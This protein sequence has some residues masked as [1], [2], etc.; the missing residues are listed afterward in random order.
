VDKALIKGDVN[1]LKYAKAATRCMAVC[2]A[3]AQ[4][5]AH[6][7]FTDDNS[8]LA[9]TGTGVAQDLQAPQQPL[10]TPEA[11][12]QQE[13]ADHL[14]RTVVQPREDFDSKDA[15]L[16]AVLASLE[17][18]QQP[19]SGSFIES[20]GDLLLQVEPNAFPLH[21][22]IPRAQHCHASGMSRCRCALWHSIGTSRKRSTWL[23]RHITIY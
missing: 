13:A 6:Q 10:L 22:D 8:S 17:G 2:Q 7:I 21:H 3:K 1:N 15:E 23:A 12:S 4:R 11:H 9:A 14:W 19:A 18:T 16:T 20:F 5:A